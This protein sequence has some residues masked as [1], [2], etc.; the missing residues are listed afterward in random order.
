M[1]ALVLGLGAL[2][3]LAWGLDALALPGWALAGA[4]VGL[5][6][7][8]PVRQRLVRV[9]VV[10][11]YPLARHALDAFG[12]LAKLALP[13]ALLPLVVVVFAS[14]GS[15]KLVEA[16]V[17]AIVLFV[18][19]AMT[20]V[21]LPAI[22]RTWVW[23]R[24]RWGYG[25]VAA[26]LVYAVGGFLVTLL[27][28]HQSHRA[29]RLEQT[30]GWPTRLAIIA[31]LIWL[32]AF[33]VRLAALGASPVRLVPLVFVGAAAIRG[34]IAL[35]LVPGEDRATSLEHWTGLPPWLLWG[36]VALVGVIGVAV[37]NE[38]H[39]RRGG[40]KWPR[41][42]RVAEA[43]G[44]NAAFVAATAFMLAILFAVVVPES[45]PGSDLSAAKRPPE[46]PAKPAWT[47]LPTSDQQLAEAFAPILMLHAQ[48]Q[49][50]LSSVE[51]HRTL[52]EVVRLSDD[53]PAPP[54]SGLPTDCGD[55]SATP[56]ACYLIRCRAKCDDG[57]EI[58]DGAGRMGT[59]Y[60]RVLR[61]GRRLDAT[62]FTVPTRYTRRLEAI[63]EYWLFYD[64]D[65]WEAVSAAGDLV[66]QHESDW[67]SVFVGL[68][69]TDPLFVGYS[70]HC[71]GTWYPWKQIEA[72]TRR[73]DLDIPGTEGRALHPL[74]AVARGSH[75]NYRSAAQNRAS[76]WGSCRG[77]SRR[78]TAA[79]SYTWN[80]RDL[81]APDFELTPEKVMVVTP[82]TPD[83]A[84]AG[85]WGDEDV[86]TLENAREFTLAGKRKPGAPPDGPTSPALKTLWANPLYA[87]FKSDAWH[88]GDTG[89]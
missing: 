55:P 29:D 35:G 11:R 68:G 22:R 46:K 52:S 32:L 40:A 71:G 16:L 67:E 17:G 86:T 41:F 62:A 57:K 1:T 82:D 28:A 76:D 85:Q 74:V 83:V 38:V 20:E 19:A 50:P 31:V 77:V 89:R 2:S 18:G 36:V 21:E 34:L 81:T 12:V 79:L 13:L 63:V 72:R 88:A 44:F 70:A 23:M 10:R 49:W 51:H 24:G 66:Q 87:I 14:R 61:R 84:F 47:A 7:Y 48:E 26:V 25:V 3:L 75:A 9:G 27:I 73:I 37:T 78:A 53:V 6:A 56:H 64:Y 54:A 45:V 65:R 42:A 4:V 5:A 30:G 39:R 59:V 80:I 15:G 58:G 60:A 69:A 33:S 8:L 43:V